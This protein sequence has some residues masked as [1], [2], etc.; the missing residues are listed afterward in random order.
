MGNAMITK[1]KHRN[2]LQNSPG[3]DS[4]VAGTVFC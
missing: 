1:I 4:A 3:S 2:A